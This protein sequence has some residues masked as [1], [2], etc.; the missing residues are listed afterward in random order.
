MASTLKSVNLVA[1]SV[2]TNTLIFSVSRRQWLKNIGEALVRFLLEYSNVEQLGDDGNVEHEEISLYAFTISMR[3]TAE[4]S[5]RV[6]ANS[7]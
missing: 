2:H 7:V 6:I 3:V 5:I 1:N 4:N